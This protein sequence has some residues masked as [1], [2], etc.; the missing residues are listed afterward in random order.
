MAMHSSILA[1]RIPW[2]VESSGLQSMGHKESNMTER[3]TFSVS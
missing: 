2:I 3:L 1:C